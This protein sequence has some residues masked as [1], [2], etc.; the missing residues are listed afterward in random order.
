MP[1]LALAL[2]AEAEPANKSVSCAM[3]TGLVVSLRK[4]DSESKL[5][6]ARC[7]CARRRPALRCL[8]NN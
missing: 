2:R 4:A 5:R 7:S 8:A 1:R 6:E 3:L